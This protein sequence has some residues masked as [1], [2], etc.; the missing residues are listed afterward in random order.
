MFF[1]FSKDQKKFIDNLLQG[2]PVDQHV[3]IV[4]GHI[5]EKESVRAIPFGKEDK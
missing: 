4:T 5:V 2:K 1:R 3:H